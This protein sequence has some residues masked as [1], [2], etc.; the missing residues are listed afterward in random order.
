MK[1]PEPLIALLE[2]QNFE[3]IPLTDDSVLDNIKSLETSD[4]VILDSLSPA[5]ISREA[6]E[7][8]ILCVAYGSFNVEQSITA[9]LCSLS[10]V[11]DFL[12]LSRPVL[13]ALKPVTAGLIERIALIKVLYP[14]RQCQTHSEM[15]FH[16]GGVEE[17]A[18]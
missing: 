2:A 6:E 17:I 18:I 13:G 14:P 3:A 12:A 16:S 15:H 11:E 4:L 9:L 7:H 5:W 10:E 1:N 8:H